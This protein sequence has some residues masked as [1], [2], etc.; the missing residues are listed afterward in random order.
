MTTLNSAYSSCNTNES[1]NVNYYLAGIS[2][3]TK[4]PYDMFRNNIASLMSQSTSEIQIWRNGIVSMCNN[5]ST[6]SNVVPGNSQ[7]YH[8][9]QNYDGCMFTLPS[10]PKHNNPTRLDAQIH[11]K[12]GYNLIQQ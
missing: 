3:V 9:Y 7:L 12:I 2:S 6:M 4:N 1:V 11:F 5:W 10:S 8:I